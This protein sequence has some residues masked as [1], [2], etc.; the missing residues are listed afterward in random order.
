MACRLLFVAI[1]FSTIVG[2]ADTPAEVAPATFAANDH[3][4]EFSVPDMMCAEGCAA[5]VKS[6]LAR[7]PGAKDVLIDFE[8]KTAIV[9]VEESK[10]DADAALAALADQMFPNSKL[11]TAGDVAPDTADDSIQ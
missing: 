6:I 3:T 9:A 10:F 2:C 1:L 5:E 7:Q 11:K 8:H 4:I